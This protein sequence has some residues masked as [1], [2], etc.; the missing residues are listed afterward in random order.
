MLPPSC[1]FGEAVQI[2]EMDMPANTTPAAA[3]VANMCTSSSARTLLLPVVGLQK[4]PPTSS[5]LLL[6]LYGFLFATALLQDRIL[7][8]AGCL[9]HIYVSGVVLAV[10][11]RP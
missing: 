10:A 2:G 1:G 5:A 9:Q 4:A 6:V 7:V 8:L 11:L 3:S